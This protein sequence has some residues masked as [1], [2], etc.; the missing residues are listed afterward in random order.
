MRYK[1]TRGLKSEEGM[2]NFVALTQWLYTNT[3][4]A[5]G[6]KDAHDLGELVA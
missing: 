1:T 5:S 4:S 2:L 6:M 3:V